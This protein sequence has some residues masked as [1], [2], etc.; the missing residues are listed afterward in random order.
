M[1]ALG[2]PNKEVLIIGSSRIHGLRWK[3]RPGFTIRVLSFSGL[4]HKDLIIKA[5]DAINDKTCILILVALQVE[6]HSRT[7]DDKV[8]LA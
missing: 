2:V 7:F 1:S 6:L 3:L 5:N 8:N 4:C